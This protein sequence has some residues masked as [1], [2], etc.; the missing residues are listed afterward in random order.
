MCKTKYTKI[1][2]A[3]E[4]KTSKNEN[5]PKMKDRFSDNISNDWYLIMYH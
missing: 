2:L 5:E 1:G 3:I 4:V